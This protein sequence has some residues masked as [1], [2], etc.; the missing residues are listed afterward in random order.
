MEN[1]N[2]KIIN[3]FVGADIKEYSSIYTLVAKM[4]NGCISFRGP[5]LI[6]GTGRTLTNIK[7]LALRNFLESAGDFFGKEADGM[8]LSYWSHDDELAYNWELI[9]SIGLNACDIKHKSLWSQICRD[10]ASYGLTMEI[11][12]GV[13]AA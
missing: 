11:K 12:G 4:P 7:L 3:V 8:C 5:Q 10:L 13:Q 2:N 1:H 9:Q 6:E